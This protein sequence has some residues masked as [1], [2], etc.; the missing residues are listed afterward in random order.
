MNTLHYGT[1]R[2]ANNRFGL[3]LTLLLLLRHIY[4]QVTLAKRTAFVNGQPVTDAF[5][6]ELMLALELFHIVILL[7]LSAADRTVIL[8][9]TG[10]VFSFRNAHNG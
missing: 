4:G 5:G 1:M 9:L 8:F 3:R 10:L 7:Q 6:V 2:G